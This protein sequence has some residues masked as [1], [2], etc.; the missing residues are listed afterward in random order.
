MSNNPIFEIQVFRS[1]ETTKSHS[2]QF[3]K[4]QIKQIQNSLSCLQT[5]PCPN[6]IVYSSARQSNINE[7]KRQFQ[8]KNFQKQTLIEQ[9]NQRQTVE[10]HM[11]PRFSLFTVQEE[12]Y[13]K[14]KQKLF[15]HPKFNL[16]FRKLVMVLIQNNKLKK[17]KVL[18]KL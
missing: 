15:Q 17:W 13:S 9:N 10:T 8:E 5:T 7:K 16:T 4:P 11:Q 2:I 12:M 6:R 3:Q 1:A 18:K 14:T